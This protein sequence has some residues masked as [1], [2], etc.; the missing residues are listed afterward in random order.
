MSSDPRGVEEMNKSILQIA[1][2]MSNSATVQTA[3]LVEHV[4][5]GDG[6]KTVIRTPVSY[7]VVADDG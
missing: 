3:V 2:A 7:E 6:M 4:P 1:E 5:A